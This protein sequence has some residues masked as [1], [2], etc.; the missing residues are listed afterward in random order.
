MTAPVV[1]KGVGEYVAMS[2]D[3][4]LARAGAVGVTVLTVRE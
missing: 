2:L 4:T 3:P 1:H